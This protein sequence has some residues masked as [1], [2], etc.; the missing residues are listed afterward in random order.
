M[1]AR[2]GQRSKKKVVIFGTGDF[3]RV[4]C[5]YLRV[6]SPYEVV[7]FTVH[8]SY[9]KRTKLMGLPVVPFEE[10]RTRY[11]PSRFSMFVAVGYKRINRC[12]AEIYE[13][14]KK[15]GY[16]LISYTHSQAV[17]WGDVAVGENC[18]ILEGNVLQP[19]VR[20]GNNV[21]LWSGNHIGHDSVIG[22]HCFIASHAVIA[23]HVTIGPYCFIGINA[24]IRDGLTVPAGCVVGAGA[25]L[26]KDA[27]PGEVF[28]ADGTRPAKISGRRFERFL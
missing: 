15:L 17:C 4:A 7:A 20:I 23:G 18:F 1:G 10:I 22:D 21:V 12:R 8:A 6:D 9:R 2:K 11:P 25:L 28:K 13:A 16:A 14:C 27:R 19:F 3:A 24:A 5:A 26:L